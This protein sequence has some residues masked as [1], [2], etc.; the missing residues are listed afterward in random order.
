MR[1]P[2]RAHPGLLRRDYID[3]RPR[4][5]KYVKLR[6]HK[7]T[8]AVGMWCD[9][10]MVLCTDSQATVLEAGLKYP[11]KKIYAMEYADW[12]LAMA[13]AG[14]TDLMRLIEE[15]VFQDLFP[16]TDKNDYWPFRVRAVLGRILK[17]VCSQ[18]KKKN[19]EL[20]C[21]TSNRDGAAGMF[22]ARNMLVTESE[23]A[24]CLGV[25]DSS[26]IRFL[27]DLF[28]RPGMTVL[29]GTVLACYMVSKATTYIDGCDGPIQATVVGNHG[30]FYNIDLS[31]WEE[32]AQLQIIEKALVR[33]FYDLCGLSNNKGAVTECLE[34]FKE[35]LLRSDFDWPRLIDDNARQNG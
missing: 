5:Y 31:T 15:R 21:A 7:M 30:T 1:L 17:D 18:H 35:Q 4:S 12:S 25:G 22:R 33:L 9:D 26:I 23:I 16:P 3:K 29:Q 2:F 28:V 24:E 32:P 20:L 10:G 19:I 8:I 14:S 34:D 11:I 27:A 13:F 6:E